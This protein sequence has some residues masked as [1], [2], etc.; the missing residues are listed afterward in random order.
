MSR[1]NCGKKIKKLE[2]QKKIRGKLN[3]MLVLNPVG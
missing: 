2:G 1:K 3:K